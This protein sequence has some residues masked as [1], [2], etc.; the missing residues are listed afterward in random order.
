MP[1]SVHLHHGAAPHI[2]YPRSARLH[3]KISRFLN[4]TSTPRLRLP[5][6]KPY[7]TRRFLPAY[8]NAHLHQQYQDPSVSGCK[9]YAAFYPQTSTISALPLST[10][11]RAAPPNN[12]NFRCLRAAS[13]QHFKKPCSPAHLH[14]HSTP[15]RNKQAAL[16][17]K[18]QFSQDLRRV[19]SISLSPIRDITS[20]L[21]LQFSQN[22]AS[23]I[24]PTL[25]FAKLLS[26]IDIYFS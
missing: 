15:P 3:Q 4:S 7:A 23:A 2:K 5:N 10:I 19:P 8:Q 26:S 6:I 18:R 14:Q 20:P 12:L 24:H 17:P 25:I 21:Q 11:N 1:R 13:Y 9:S 22:K 16:S